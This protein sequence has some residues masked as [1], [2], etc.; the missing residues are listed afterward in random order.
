M[1]EFSRRALLEGERVYPG[2][3]FESVNDPGE[4]LILQRMVNLF[5]RPLSQIEGEVVVPRF[6]SSGQ[7]GSRD[8]LPD[9]ESIL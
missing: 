6:P 1:V 2:F 8:L 4:G 7:S 9:L 5:A 3:V